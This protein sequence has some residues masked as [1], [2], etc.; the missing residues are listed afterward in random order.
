[1]ATKKRTRKKS[2]AKSAGDG[3]ALP[4][5][6]DAAGSEAIELVLRH[7]LSE[8]YVY[9]PGVMKS[10]EP[11]LTELDQAPMGAV[12]LKKW[13]PGAGAQRIRVTIEAV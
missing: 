13:V 1:M 9:Y 3:A 6:K 5:T 11:E 2:S 4:P 8:C 7:E 12:Y 10:G